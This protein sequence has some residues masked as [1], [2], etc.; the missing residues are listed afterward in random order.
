MSN[1]GKAYT[2]AKRGGPRAYID[3]PNRRG[4]NL[5]TLRPGFSTYYAIGAMA[6]KRLP[7][8]ATWRAIGEELGVTS[9][10]AYTEGVLA[11][12]KLLYGIAQIIREAP[13]L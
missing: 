7:V 1:Q 2:V 3:N 11:L 8:H 4:K 12:G 6:T 13:E 5:F 10:N 9:Q